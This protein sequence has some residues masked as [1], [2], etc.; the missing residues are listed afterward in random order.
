MCVTVG[1]RA[2]PVVL[3]YGLGLGLEGFTGF[4]V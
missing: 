1:N 4:S 3:V 2:A